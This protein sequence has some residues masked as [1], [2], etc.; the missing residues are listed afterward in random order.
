MIAS[1]IRRGT[2]L[3]PDFGIALKRHLLLDTIER[4]SDTG[5]RQHLV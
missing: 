5:M 2:F 1:D 3:A 4:A